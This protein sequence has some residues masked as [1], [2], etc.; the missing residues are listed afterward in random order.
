[1]LIHFYNVDD[2]INSIYTTSNKDN[3]SDKDKSVKDKSVKLD[4]KHD[5]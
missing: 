1:M 4:I 2:N 3:A 5:I